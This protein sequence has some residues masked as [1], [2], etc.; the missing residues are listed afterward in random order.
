MNRELEMSRLGVDSAGLYCCEASESVASRPIPAVPNPL[1][2]AGC[3]G[4]PF[5]SNPRIT[6]AVLMKPR[7]RGVEFVSSR[8]LF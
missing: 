8:H 4:I 2:V 6:I 7:S 1:S 3:A 5:Q